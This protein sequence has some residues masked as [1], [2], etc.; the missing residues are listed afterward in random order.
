MNYEDEAQEEQLFPTVYEP[1]LDTPGIA[2]S[3][4]PACG[5]AG[6]CPCFD[7]IDEGPEDGMTDAEGEEF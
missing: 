2:D 4:C 7:P 5:K 3:I 1:E 6:V